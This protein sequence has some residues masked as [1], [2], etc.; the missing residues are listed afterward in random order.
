M[1]PIRKTMYM[2]IITET[3]SDIITILTEAEFVYV[4]PI[5]RFTTE[6]IEII[7]ELNKLMTSYAS[8]KESRIKNMYDFHGLVSSRDFQRDSLDSP[9]PEDIQAK[10]DAYH[11]DSRECE[12]LDELISQTT[13]KYDA[14]WDELSEVFDKWYTPEQH[15][16]FLVTAAKYELAMDSTVAVTWC[17]QELDE[18]LA[19]LEVA[20]DSAST[21]EEVSAIDTHIAAVSKELSEVRVEREKAMQQEDILARAYHQHV[22]DHLQTPCSP[23]VTE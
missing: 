7:L 21:T 13:R 12:R 2:A 6:Q 19:G 5:F 14:I 16:E 17:E 9:Y 18:E 4:D 8:T 20:R 15:L 10:L 11:R 23:R 22:R 3:Q 1:V